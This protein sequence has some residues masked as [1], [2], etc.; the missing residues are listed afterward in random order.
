MNTCTVCGREYDPVAFRGCIRTDC[1]IKSPPPAPR[2]ASVLFLG[3]N[4]RSAVFDV[5]AQIARQ[6]GFQERFRMGG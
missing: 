6:V 4:C 2:P 3:I 5:N 1:P